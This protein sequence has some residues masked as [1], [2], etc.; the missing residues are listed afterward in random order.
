[1][2]LK[3][4]KFNHKFTYKEYCSWPND[5]RWELI[6]GVAYDMSPAPS[7]RHQRISFKLSTQIGIFLQISRHLS[8][9]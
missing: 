7:S 4:E 9:W 3:K 2:G 1:M 5:E 6:D 8:D